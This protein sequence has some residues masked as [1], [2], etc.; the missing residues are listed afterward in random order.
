MNKKLLHIAAI[1]SLLPIYLNA[2]EI[3]K[4][5]SPKPLITSLPTDKPLDLKIRFIDS[6]EAM[7]LCQN[8]QKAAK[9]LETKREKLTQEIQGLEKSYTQAVND[10]KVKSSTMSEFA[11]E[12]AEKDIRKTE[13]DYKTKLQ[14]SEYE[15]KLA[16]QKATEELAKEVELAV[17]EIAK[18]EKLD[19]VADIMTGRVIYASEKVILTDK[20]VKEMDKQRDIKLAQNKSPKQDDVKIAKKDGKS[21]AISA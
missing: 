1:F 12:K 18:K 11:R 8:G 5:S 13:A 15:M 4:S 14:E 10:F 6:F 19:A 2:E 7:R 16:M 9:E 20:L 21:T 3:S 17:A